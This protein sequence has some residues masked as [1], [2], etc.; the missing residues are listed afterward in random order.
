MKCLFYMKMQRE[1]K[2]ES[3][4]EVGFVISLTLSACVAR[5]KGGDRYMEMKEEVSRL[6]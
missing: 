1:R 3:K 2:R 4:S 6:G 5:K